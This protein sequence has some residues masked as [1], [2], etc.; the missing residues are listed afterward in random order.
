VIF[1]L[2]IQVYTWEYISKLYKSI[3]R[4]PLI[5][6]AIA[7]EVANLIFTDVRYK[8]S[9]RQTSAALH[10]H[11][12][13]GTLTA[14]FLTIL[15]Q[16]VVQWYFTSIIFSTLGVSR[17]AIFIDQ[18]EITP[19]PPPV[20]VTGNILQDIGFLL[21]DGLMVRLTASTCILY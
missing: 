17:L 1:N 11:I 6:Y 3:V 4:D 10:R 16:M 18:V 15:A 9:G 8:V 13:V 12:I 19:V 20:A 14:L 7:R 5:Y 21:A 2:S